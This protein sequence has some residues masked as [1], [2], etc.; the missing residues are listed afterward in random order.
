SQRRCLS[1]RSGSSS[2]FTELPYDLAA[3]LRAS[4]TVVYLQQ[5]M[6]TIGRMC[7]WTSRPRFRWRSTSVWRAGSSASY[8][9]RSSHQRSVRVLFGRPYGGK[10]LSLL[11]AVTARPENGASEAEHIRRRHKVLNARDV[12]SNTFPVLVKLINSEGIR[13]STRAA[14]RG[15]STDFLGSNSHSP[16]LSPSRHRPGSIIVRHFQQRPHATFQRGF[17]PGAHPGHGDRPREPL[18]SGSSGSG[19][20]I[21]SKM[22]PS[23]RLR[24]SPARMCLSRWGSCSTPV[25]AWATNFELPARLRSNFSKL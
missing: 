10:Y 21:S 22:A 23:K 9:T 16:I 18:R 4:V 13:S 14:S 2:K 7:T 11:S 17:H 1:C 3:A 24:T 5:P 12:N 15:R 25:V 20:F 6:R 19:T 8:F